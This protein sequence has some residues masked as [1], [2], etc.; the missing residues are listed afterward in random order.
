MK[1]RITS[2]DIE[3]RL[4]MVASECLYFTGPKGGKYVAERFDRRGRFSVA[5]VTGLKAPWS[6][7]RKVGRFVEVS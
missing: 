6:T 4:G 3:S 2:I 1:L 7:A 5:H